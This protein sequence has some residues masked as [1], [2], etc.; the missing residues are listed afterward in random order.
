[1]RGLVGTILVL[2]AGLVPSWA[3]DSA[4]AAFNDG[5]HERALE[6]Y[7]ARLESDPDDLTALVRSGLLLSWS[8]RFDEAIARYDRA[9]AVQ[10]GH[11]K[12][13]L[14]RAKVLSWDGRH[15]ESIEAFRAY[16][17]VH[18]D[19]REARLGLARCLS[20]SRRFDESREEFAVVLR[21]DPNETQAIVGTARTH[22]WS[23][24]LAQARQWYQ[25]ALEIDPHDKDAGMGLAYVYLWTGAAAQAEQKAWELQRRYP[26]DG[27][28]A[29]LT[30]RTR[31][32]IAPRA[33]ADFDRIEDTDDN[34]LNILRLSGGFSLL[35]TTGVRLSYAH[36]DLTNNDE[37]ATIDSWFAYLDLRPTLGQSLTLSLGV[38][39]SDNNINEESQT[40][41]LGGL[42]YVWGLDRRWQA[43]GSAGRQA[44]RYSPEIT[45]N[46]IRF[47][48]F[49]AG[50]RG[51]VGQ[52]WRVLAN[53]SVSDFS[54][55]N[56][57]DNLIAGFVYN[58]PLERPR[59]DLGYTIQYMNYAENTNSG[60][61]DPQDFTSNLASAR[62][63][64]NFGARRNT[65]RAEVEA[66]YQSFTLENQGAGGED[67]E[68]DNDFV[69]VLTGVLGFPLN[70]SLTL[71]GQVS[72]GDY[73]AQT[74]A[75][76]ES[77]LI[78]IRLHWRGGR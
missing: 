20:W 4:D 14:E 53:A 57:R 40:D 52:R 42:D 1:L 49:R 18:P 13:L 21:D 56:E 64:G 61:F 31:A 25:R 8:D 58:V 17:V 65:W 69:V 37:D 72:W 12:A 66:G 11:S 5:D 30:L 78:G 26:T 35:P 34:E 47:D 43:T 22:A 54:D 77:R 16:L 55:N 36:Y 62:A 75:G 59:L 45:S 28:I 32:A 6:L 50:V 15:D 70:R 23:G 39:L 71:E 19:D 46:N 67:V 44:L 63:S 73:A 2:L 9:L 3:A 24:Q 27:D 7:D 41:A 33:R 74:A 38:D 60:Y 10:P 76:F 51:R 48:Y 29:E 68:V